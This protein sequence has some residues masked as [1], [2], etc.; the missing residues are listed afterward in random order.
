MILAYKEREF[1]EQTVNE[2][3]GVYGCRQ[4][5]WTYFDKNENET[6]RKIIEHF[7]KY[8]RCEFEWR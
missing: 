4:I 2:S 8:R 3:S 1:F 6:L 5:F 7:Q